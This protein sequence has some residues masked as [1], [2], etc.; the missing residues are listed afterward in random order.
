VGST[1]KAQYLKINAYLDRRHV[2][3]AKKLLWEF[4]VVFAWSY[5]DLKGIPPSLA[6]HK[7]ELERMF[8]Q[9]TRPDTG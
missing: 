9:Q 1:N 3:K 8:M 5:K 6:E 4:K 2:A 7:I